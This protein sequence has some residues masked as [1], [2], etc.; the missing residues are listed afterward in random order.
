MRIVAKFQFTAPSE[1]EEI[2]QRIGTVL[3]NWSSRKFDRT[4][5]G[6]VVIRHSGASAAFEK[7]TE[8]IE[9][10]RHDTFTILE[11]VDG[12]NLQ[13]DVDILAASGR[14]A[15]RCVL[16]IGSDG[17]IAPADVSLRAPRFVRE[18]V[19][20][21]GS[22][23]MGVSGERVFAHSFLVDVDHVRELEGLM[24]AIER[25][26]PIVIVSELL[27]ETLAGDL[28]E[29]LSQDLCGLAHT[30]RLSHEAS[31]E[32]TRSRGKEWSCYNG[33]VRLLWPFR[34]NNHD[35]RVH[36]LW[37]LDQILSRS[38]NEVQARDRIRGV[39]ADRII[40][41][42]T[43]VA[44]D[45][46][47][48]DFEVAKVR[49]AADQ[50]RSAATDDGDIRAL[51]NAYA[52]EN[53]ALRARVD[54]QDKELEVLRENV[55]T[56]TIALRSSQAITPEN[57]S[58]APPQTV[59]EAVAVARSELSNRVVIA[60]ETDTDIADLNPSAGP[61]D[62]ILRY[63]R[64]LGA[65]A[66]TLVEGA[67]GQSMPI[68]LRERGVECSVDSETGKASKE[69]KRFR[70]RMVNGESVNCE[71][72]AKPSEG[73]S[74]D[75]CVRIYFAIAVSAPFVKVGYIGRHSA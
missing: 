43:F 69:G 75:M 49:R 71:F 55:E 48:R 58:E 16:S 39:I 59:E 3:D 38:G 45:P 56:L 54:D 67:L 61:S 53:D 57:V 28:H 11:P 10:R 31:W 9:D 40:E 63:L 6:G 46:A 26:L 5:D 29:R 51:A 66:D 30:V 47:F 15:F 36:P 19:A 44:D 60:H 74:P 27:G 12:G 22:W 8:T 35:F 14:T 7:S 18:I 34:S 50:A 41:A 32:L 4:E 70:N 21:G 68:W 62:K 65:L 24:A 20:S 72:H 2:A 23:T 42:S 25:R 64:T 52:V 33:A 17:G 37:T 13:T 73:V 1:G